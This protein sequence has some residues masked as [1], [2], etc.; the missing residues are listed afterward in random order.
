MPCPSVLSFAHTCVRGVLSSGGVAIDATAGNGHDTLALAEYAQ[1]GGHVFAF[2]VQQAALDA[3]RRRLDA[4]GATDVVTLLQASHDTMVDALPADCHGAVDTVMF[5]LGYLPGSDKTV[6]TRPAT[7]VPALNQALTLLRPGG[8][9]TVVL[10][11]GHDGGTEEARAVMD[12]ATTLDPSATQV[13][14]YRTINRTAAPELI[15]LERT[16]A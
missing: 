2:D 7:T 8:V 6:I 4:A 1:P 16:L 14:S 15:A 13:H 3:T 11:R 5:N 9:L 10:Y 12:W